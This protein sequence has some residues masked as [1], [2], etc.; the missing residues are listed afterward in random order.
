M[1][2]V[3]HSKNY[4]LFKNLYG[5]FRRPKSLADAKHIADTLIDLFQE[6]LSLRGWPTIAFV[7]QLWDFR[8]VASG[9]G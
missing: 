9:E 1:S 8:K 4:A 2:N 5:S 6:E 7:W 3:D